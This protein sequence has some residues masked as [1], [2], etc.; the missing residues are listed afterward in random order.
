[1]AEGAGQ[2]LDY[3]NVS[4]SAARRWFRRL[5]MPLLV[6][7]LL[8]VLLVT[9]YTF[10][11]VD[12]YLIERD[13]TWWGARRDEFKQL[14]RRTDS[15]RLT[16]GAP[17]F[18]EFAREIAPHLLDGLTHRDQSIR[19]RVAY[20]LLLIGIEQREA[21]D[22]QAPAFANSTRD[23]LLRQLI[24]GTDHPGELS[25]ALA[26]ACR[27]TDLTPV[28]RQWDQLNVETRHDVMDLA[29]AWGPQMPG[30]GEILLR[31]VASSN[32]S[33]QVSA[34]VALHRWMV[35][36][37]EDPFFKRDESYYPADPRWEKARGRNALPPAEA[38]RVCGARLI[39]EWEEH[40]SADELYLE[41]I[42]YVA[43]RAK[44]VD[45]DLLRVLEE[46][47]SSDKCGTYYRKRASVAADRLRRAS[48]EVEATSS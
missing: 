14:R 26:Y 23:L 8:A 16:E 7:S 25:V 6:L 17:S 29:R 10:W 5:R 37:S 19:D 3:A 9:P 45:P 20:L 28:L 34:R 4:S 48:A 38:L 42:C 33:L 1:M 21:G 40:E 22:P 43:D 30:G 12:D 39:E 27:P 47:A 2:S 24:E 13:R 32:G 41:V 35:F 18:R 46:I 36:L 31:G 44:T 15:S 11:R